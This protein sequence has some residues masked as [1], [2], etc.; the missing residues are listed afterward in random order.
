MNNKEAEEHH[1]K[2][3]D[4]LKEIM[5]NSSNKIPNEYKIKAIGYL[6]LNKTF[7]K[8]ELSASVVSKLRTIWNQGII[9][10]SMGHH[11]CEFCNK[12][13]S[14]SEK[15]LKDEVNKIQYIFPEMIFHY[16]EEHNFMP[17]ADFILFIMRM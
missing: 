16:I 9:I 14:S 2:L 17:D 3:N 11:D 15:I 4:G 1:K 6:T 5:K 10:A 12:A 8:G 7:E 13:K